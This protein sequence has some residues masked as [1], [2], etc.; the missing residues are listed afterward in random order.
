VIDLGPAGPWHHMSRCT[1]A[2]TTEAVEHT[3]STVDMG[4]LAERFLKW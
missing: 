2:D 3:R 1:P 4:A